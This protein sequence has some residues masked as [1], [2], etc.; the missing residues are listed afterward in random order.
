VSSPTIIVPCLRNPKNAQP[1]VDGKYD[2]DE[3]LE[4]KNLHLQKKI[5]IL[6]AEN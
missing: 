3:S 4:K 1:P 2:D 6:I 5:S